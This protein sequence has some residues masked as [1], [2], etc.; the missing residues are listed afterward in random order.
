MV[1][2]ASVMIIVLISLILTRVATVALIQT[3]LS[4]ETARFQARSA[5]TGTGFTTSESESIVNHPVRRRLVRSLMLIG[6]AG[7]VT[8]IATL[9][10]SF[11]NADRTQTLSRL[12]VL[13]IALAV[14]LLLARNRR[15]DAMMMR[16]IGRALTRWTDIDAR[17]YMGLLHL[18]QGYAV[19]ELKLR[20][21]DWIT[22]RP[23]RGLELRNEGVA[24]LA[25]VCPNGTY[26]GTPE[27]DSAPQPEDTLILYGPT[28][29]LAELDRRQSGAEGDQAHVDAVTAQKGR[30]TEQEQEEKAAR[31]SGGPSLPGEPVGW[32]PDS[33]AADS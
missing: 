16:V 23:L 4:R 13:I 9:M 28:E 21:G 20:E 7:V 31:R 3:G 5:L 6:S 22:G 25:I 30:F 18:G 8:V 17:D 29:R 33:A 1:A 27:R 2:I 24:V 10:L 32:P 14:I 15:V 12:G 26:I 11:V 19:N